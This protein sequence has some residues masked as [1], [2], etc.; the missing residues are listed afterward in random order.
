M[1][2]CCSCVAVML[3]FLEVLFE[4]VIATGDLT[5]PLL[6]TGSLN[7]PHTQGRSGDRGNV[8]RWKPE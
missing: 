4:V 5:D 7:V 1:I 6:D 8:S 3:R 2:R